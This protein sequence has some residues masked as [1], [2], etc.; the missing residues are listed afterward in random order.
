MLTHKDVFVGYTVEMV[1][2][3]P[4]QGEYVLEGFT[5]TIPANTSLTLHPG[6]NGMANRTL[7][8]QVG[9]EWE[10]K[11]WVFMRWGGLVGTAD[12]PG[13]AHLWRD[14]TA[15]EP[16]AEAKAKQAL[17]PEEVSLAWIDPAGVLVETQTQAVKADDEAT[18]LTKA[19]PLG[20]PGVWSVRMMAGGQ[21]I[22][23]RHFP[24]IRTQASPLDDTYADGAI[25]KGFWQSRLACRQESGGRMHG[26]TG[27]P[28][29]VDTAW[30]SLS[31]NSD[32][33]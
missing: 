7:D 2:R 28:S 10:A 30:S 25:V 18:H 20:T 17:P 1:V 21:V 4:Q 22:A 19:G 11:E 3:D 29:C 5:E 27:L 23:A 31:R 14:A 6:R 33:D 8:L 26:C 9:M 16:K 24:A 12:T 13:S 32:M 15:E